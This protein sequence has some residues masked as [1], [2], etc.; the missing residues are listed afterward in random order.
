[1]KALTTQNIRN[2]AIVS[3]SGAGKTTLLEALLFTAGVTTRLGKV[4]EG[5]T[6]SD[7]DP[8][9]VRRRSSLS[10][11]VAYLFWREQKINI[12]DAPGLLDFVGEVKSA[13]YPA[14]AALMLVSA[15]SGVEVGTELYWGSLEERGMPRAFLV[16]KIDKENASFEKTMKDLEDAFG[17]AVTPLHLPVGK[18]AAFEGVVDLLQMKT[19]HFPEGSG[20]VEVR[21]IPKEQAAEAEKYRER[22]VEAATEADDAMLEKYL[23]GQELNEEEIRTGLRKAILAGKIFPI[24]CAS[25]FRNQGSAALLD[26]ILNSFPSPLETGNLQALNPKT[27]EQVTIKPDKEAPLAALVWKT[28]ADPYVGKITLLRLYAGTLR[29]D[30]RLLNTTREVEERISQPFFLRGKTQEGAPELIAGDIGAIS[31]LSETKTG[32]TLCEKEHPLLLPPLRFPKPVISAAIQPRSKGDEDRI[33]NAL[34]RMVEED[35]TI[36]VRR[37]AEVGQTIVSGLGQSHL[38][39]MVERMKRKFSID[40]NLEP[41]KVPYKETIRTSVKVE[42]KYKKQTGGHGQYGHCWVEFSPVERGKGFEFENRIVGGVIPKQYIPAVE[43]GI[44]ES[45]EK[46]ILAGFPVVDFKAAVYDGS[47]HTV[48]SSELAFKVAASLAFKKGMQDAKPVILEPIVS[49][50]VRV[51]EAY[52]GDVISDLNSK[53]GRI[54]GMDSAGKTQA[55]KAQVPLAEMLSYASDLTSITQGRGYYTMEFSHYEEVPNQL[56]E[57]IIEKALAEKAEEKE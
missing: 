15:V 17:K 27:R 50:E 7:F 4:E 52:M 18:E 13:L 3:H 28:M 45:M 14:D 32:D 26:F 56:A 36:E 1:M 35:P 51:P 40:V 8:E 34:A 25:P 12:L 37:D 16:T 6:V 33:S 21:E 10:A 29:P 20:Q 39:A 23:D 24:L 55:I 30:S 19:L 48:D 44:R 22:L 38:E 9:E 53:R 57:G 49:V 11:T 43:K 41:P 31:K 5:N 47:Y 54:L 42:G 2:V 46:G